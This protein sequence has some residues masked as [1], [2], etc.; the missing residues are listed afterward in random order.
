M[1]TISPALTTARAANYYKNELAG[2]YYASG[3]SPASWWGIGAARLGLAGAVTRDDFVAVLSGR[4]PATGEHLVRG[5]NAHGGLRPA[6][7]D[8][9]FAAPK[10]VSILACIGGDSRLISAHER[11]VSAALGELE[12]YVRCR[13]S[14]RTDEGE[15][16]FNL[17]VARFRH[18]TSR[19]LDPHLHTHCVTA[20][21]TL[22]TDKWR[23]IEARELFRLQR[24]ATAVYRAELARDIRRLGYEIEIGGR[25]E[26]DIA[27]ISEPQCR[28][29]SQRRR[30]IE[31]KAAKEKTT[32]AAEGEKLKRRTRRAKARIDRA[33]LQAMWETRAREVD[34]NAARF[35]DAARSNTPSA[36]RLDQVESTLE[37]SRD[38]VSHAINHVSERESAAPLTDYLTEALVRGLGT[39]TI[40]DLR[41]E[42]DSRRSRREF[43]E[44]ERDREIYSTPEMLRMESRIVRL[45]QDGRGAVAPIAARPAVLSRHPNLSR[46]QLAAAEFVLSTSDRV[47]GIQADAGTGKS[48]TAVAIADEAQR[49]GYHVIG[50]A[51]FSG[52]VKAL[53][54]QG[55]VSRTVESY[56]RRNPN[57]LAN[58][59][60][61][62]DESGT[63]STM[64]MHAL[65]D[66]ARDVDARVL[67][68]GDTRRRGES[69]PG[70]HNAVAAGDPFRLLQERGMAIASLTEKFRQEGLQLK[71]VADAAA[72][73]DVR[74]AFAA[75]TG[76]D[77]VHSIP[78]DDEREAAIALDFAEH[79]TNT[80]VVAPS[81]AARDRLNARIRS[82]LQSR[83]LV[84]VEGVVI[85]TLRNR[86]LTEAQRIVAGSY[87]PGNV[88]R[89]R[90]GSAK[91]GIPKSEEARVESVEAL[92]N[93]VT[94]R[95]ADG[96]L[97]TYDPRRLRGVDVFDEIDREFGVGDRLAF[98]SVVRHTSGKIPNG[99]IVRIRELES[100]GLATL[101]IRQ[102]GRWRKVK[103]DLSAAREIDH[104]YVTTS[105]ASQGLTVDR[106]S[107]VIDARD[108]A[109]ARLVNSTQ[110]YVSISRARKCAQIWTD[111][112]ATLEARVARRAEKVNALD[113]EE[114]NN[115]EEDRKQD[116][117]FA[118]SGRPSRGDRAVEEVGRGRV[119]GRAA[120]NG[121][122]REDVREGSTG[123]DVRPRWARRRAN[124][125][126]GA[127]EVSRTGGAARR[128]DASDGLTA[129]VRMTVGT[130]FVRLLSEVRSAIDEA[131]SRVGDRL[132]SFV[133]RESGPPARA[134]VDP[135]AEHRRALADAV[136]TGTA[137]LLD[138]RSGDDAYRDAVLAESLALARWIDETDASRL[139]PAVSSRKELLRHAIIAG[140]S[141][142]PTPELQALLERNLA[143]ARGEQRGN[144]REITR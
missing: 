52:A 47:I 96:T 139:P 57:G 20:N 86:N 67:L 66:R 115:D 61:L 120:R 121:A 1:L 105:H 131:Y 117:G 102:R 16:T 13:P 85:R 31:A 40:A 38:A 129:D 116:A 135:E 41:S 46:E 44:L 51:P 108:A 5:S 26:V 84:S 89:Y 97:R 127:G 78:S 50:L 7:W 118:G 35:V 107:V 3:A 48:V 68:L 126:R 143:R 25:G 33:E 58:Q 22:A 12:R 76:L 65:L 54:D 87:V 128:A 113:W 114:I 141:G 24:F 100:N 14:H 103:L 43:V 9:T 123:G 104:G 71:R 106:V 69:R 39:S 92:A 8:L 133:G 111:D 37:A 109:S 140:M 136:R 101:A 23:A 34:L 95:L 53:T 70:Q 28:E 90:R 124:S 130:R 32:I 59:L 80:L 17:V 11:A 18:E 42:F 81:N 88:V 99:T 60:W 74:E 56:L 112:A 142:T 64:Q 134:V 138:G 125:R 91:F 27:A 10:S 63:I 15:R 93:R 62:V 110:F 30:A 75:L 49:A 19:E 55:I 72:R 77:A 4:H 2:D 82:D 21:L 79:S 137:I 94:V 73:G 6:A 45:M 144:S 132:S 119:P 98:R 36:S 29:F 122:R 83:G